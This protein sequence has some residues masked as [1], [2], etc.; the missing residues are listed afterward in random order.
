MNGMKENF[1]YRLLWA[2]EFHKTIVPNAVERRDFDAIATKTR[3]MPKIRQ[4]YGFQLQLKSLKITL[5]K[6]LCLLQKF[7]ALRINLET[8][9]EVTTDS[10]THTIISQFLMFFKN[11]LLLSS[12][13]ISLFLLFSIFTC[14]EVNIKVTHR[15]AHIQKMVRLRL[16]CKI[17]C[18]SQKRAL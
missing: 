8:N 15:H 18:T 17:T 6:R 16:C 1:I 12:S 10:S 14:L 2:D 4:F 5:G 7:R 9:T 13:N 3:M 11:V